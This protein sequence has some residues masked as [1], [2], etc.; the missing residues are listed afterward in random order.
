MNWDAGACRL[1]LQRVR[2]LEEQLEK[3][4]AAGGG[5]AGRA[6]AE[7]E[8]AL[9]AAG[10][11][12]S[13]LRQE[14]A[15]AGAELNEASQGRVEQ[16]QM[17]AEQVMKFEKESADWQRKLERAVAEAGESDAIKQALEAANDSRAQVGGLT[18]Q[19]E[20]LGAVREDLENRLAIAIEAAAASWKSWRRNWSEQAGGGGAG[21]CGV[22][23]KDSGSGAKSGARGRTQIAATNRS[24][25]SKG[26]AAILREREELAAKA[27]TLEETS[28]AS[29]LVGQLFSVQDAL[30]RQAEEGAAWRRTAWRA[31]VE[32][33][34]QRNAALEKARDS[35]G[36]SAIPSPPTKRLRTAADASGAALG[37]C[38]PE[39]SLAIAAAG[40]NASGLSPA[41]ARDENDSGEEQRGCRAAAG[42]T[43]VAQGKSR[44]GQASFGETGNGHGAETRRSHRAEDSGGGRHLSDHD[45]GQRLLRRVQIRHADVSE[46]GNRSTGAP[47][48]FAG[49]GI[50]GV[51]DPADGCHALGGRDIRAAWKILRSRD[52]HYGDARRARGM[53]GVAGASC[54][55]MNLEGGHAAA[56]RFA[57]PGR[58]R[59]G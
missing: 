7:L 47:R 38:E 49:G 15:Q 22:E 21:D 6:R 34:R 5:M 28:V 12:V 37:G 13:G 3:T 51:A 45:P 58:M 54:L 46:R 1:M 56:R 30:R 50:A 36:E 11:Q 41:G 25:S 55:T 44:T 33:L 18:K 24:E 23:G 4:N 43:A 26:D 40:A 57:T 27:E 14:L 8:G 29:D 52:E 9:A 48:P 53:G 39:A 10:E 19:L 42:A 16:A 32:E 2:S 20:E 17:L 31:K 35:G 59:R